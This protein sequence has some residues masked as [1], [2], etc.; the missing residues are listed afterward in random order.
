MLKGMRQQSLSRFV[1][2]NTEDTISTPL[3]H[4]QSFEQSNGN[5][6]KCPPT[7]DNFYVSTNINSPEN[8]TVVDRRTRSERYSTYFSFQG[9]K[10]FV[11]FLIFNIFCDVINSIL[12]SY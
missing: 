8:L 6:K 12:L 1:R 11:L 2:S 10:I 7:G 3:T 5:V 4:T 9:F